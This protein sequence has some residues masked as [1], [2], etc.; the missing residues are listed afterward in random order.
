MVVIDLG[1][2]IEGDW[3][4][5]CFLPP[6]TNNDLAREVLSIEFDAE[7]NSGVYVLDSITLVVI[8]K[9]NTVLE[10]FET[11]RNNVDFASL[12]ANNQ[13]E[14]IERTAISFCVF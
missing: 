12:N 8:I 11:P 13:I 6:Y 7:G 5:V 9:Q 4:K 1:K 2:E 14:Q 3:D 10:C